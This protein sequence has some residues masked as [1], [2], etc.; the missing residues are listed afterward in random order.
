MIICPNLS[1][2]DVAQEF[3]EL[4]SAL[5]AADPKHGEAMAY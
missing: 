1:N 2:P 4:K 5:E 3:N